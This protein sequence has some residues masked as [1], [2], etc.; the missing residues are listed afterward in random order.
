LVLPEASKN[1]P[2]KDKQDIQKYVKL[3]L[4]G[5]AACADESFSNSFR[6]LSARFENEKE[7]DK[8]NRTRQQGRRIVFPSKKDSKKD[9]EQRKGLPAQF[10]AVDK[11]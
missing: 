5:I 11:Q 3:Q 1:G 8:T 10:P 9:R 6:K 2:V 4:E 7:G